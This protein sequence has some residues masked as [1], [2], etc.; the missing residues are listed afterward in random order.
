QLISEPIPTAY[1]ISPRRCGFEMVNGTE[2]AAQHH[3][4]LSPSLQSNRMQEKGV[5]TVFSLLN[6]HSLVRIDIG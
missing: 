1:S 3:R 2:T 4:T 6:A 5:A